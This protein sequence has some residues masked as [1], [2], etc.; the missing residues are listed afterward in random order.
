MIL[1]VTTQT[2]VVLHTCIGVGCCVHPISIRLLSNSTHLRA[3][4]NKEADYASDTN[5]ITNLILCA[6]DITAPLKTR[7][8]TFSDR[9]M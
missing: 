4:T 9:Y 3:V 1:F 7:I 8:G 6:I 5:D 2:V